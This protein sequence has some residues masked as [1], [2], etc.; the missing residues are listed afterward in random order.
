MRVA[1]YNVE[2]FFDTGKYT[3]SGA[4]WEYTVEFVDE[5][6]RKLSAK[7]REVDADILLLQEVGS[8]SAVQKLIKNT[9]IPYDMFAAEPDRFGVRNVAL[10]RVP[11][12]QKLSIP[13]TSPLPTF[14]DTDKDNL[15][16]RI[17][18]RR[19]FVYLVSEL[20][21]KQ[22]HIIGLHLKA[23][24]LIGTYDENGAEHRRFHTQEDA[25]NGLIRSELFRL[26]QAKKVRR[27]VDRIL[28]ADN[29]SYIIV[30][31]DFNAREADSV[32]KIISGAEPEL[33]GILR[34][35]T[36]SID[37]G[38]RYSND[39]L[40]SGRRLIDDILCSESLLS[41]VGNVR[42]LNHGLIPHKN[43]PPRPTHSDSDHA[44][45]YIDLKREDERQ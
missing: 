43:R 30:A 13:T 36:V 5:R 22:L 1:T 31:G 6:I 4:E 18:S 35:A 44:P 29:T 11:V 10:F 41:E 14:S 34:S 45:I 23:N 21:G 26:S 7:L 8:L 19:D 9:G 2:F 3:H 16:Q 37:P 39:S 38:A 25:A 28:A 32:R 17:P 24:F 33:G 12:S 42:I 40:R 20:S 15:S 27:L